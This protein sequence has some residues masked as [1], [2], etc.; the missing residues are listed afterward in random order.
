MNLTFTPLPNPRAVDPEL[1]AAVRSWAV[2]REPGLAV[3][4]EPWAEGVRVKMTYLGVETGV[5]FAWGSRAAETP[6]HATLDRLF[7]V[8]SWR[9]SQPPGKPRG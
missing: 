6:V 5:M 3:A 2:G 7:H 8:L 9:V 4:V 1:V